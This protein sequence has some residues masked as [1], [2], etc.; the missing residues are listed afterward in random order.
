LSLGVPRHK[1]ERGRLSYVLWQEE[2]V[3]P[4]LALE[5]IS[6][7]YNGEYEAKLETYQDIGILYYVIY[8]PLASQKRKHKNRLALEVYKLVNGAYQLIPANEHGVVWLPEISVGIGCEVRS[9]A[10][11]EREWLHLYDE[12]SNRYLTDNEIAKQERLLAAQEHSI[13]VQERMAK[14]QAEQKAQRLAEKLRSMGIDPDE[15]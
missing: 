13:A 9:V 15:I 1:G 2:N 8:N 3:M 11:W 6:E 4:I 5:V 7:K 12:A 14:Q 10:S